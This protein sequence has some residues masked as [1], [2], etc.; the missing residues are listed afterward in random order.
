MAVLGG[1]VLVATSMPATEK[2]VLDWLLEHTDNLDLSCIASLEYVRSSPQMGVASAFTFGWGY[3]GLRMALLALGI[4]FNEVRPRAWQQQLGIPKRGK[5][6][7]N[8]HW[9]NRLKIRAQELFPTVKVTLATADALLLAEY[10]RRTYT[11]TEA[12][13]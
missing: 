13:A 12:S 3:G 11:R 5:S 10:C 2:D 9:K 1:G 7:D 4:P 8:T 6:E